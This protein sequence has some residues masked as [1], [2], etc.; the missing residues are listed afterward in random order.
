VYV[1]RLAGTSVFDPI[2][3]QVGKVRDVVLLMGYPHRQR[4]RAVGLVLEVPG[5]RRVFIPLSRV[6]SMDTGQVITTGLVNMRR[7]AQRATE[8]LALAEVL[9][10]TVTFV[11]GSGHGTVEDLAIEQMRSQ[12][13]EVTKVYVRRSTG[14]RGLSD[15]LRRRRGEL[16]LVDTGQIK[17]LGIADL[18]Q[19]ATMLVAG[20]EEM[21]AA[22]IADMLHDMP[23]ERQLAVA[24]ELDD[25][26][27]ADV[28]EEL[29]DDDQ[30]AILSHLG[31][32]RA[33]DVL[34]EMEPD[35]AADLLSELSAEEQEVFLEAM[36]PEEADDLRRLM[37]YEDNTAGGLMTSE[38]I[39]VPPEATVAEALAMV[40]KTEVSPFLAAAVFVCRPPM[41]T[42]TGRYLGLVH[43]QRLL[44]EPPH[45]AIGNYV[46]S[47]IASLGA[48][49]GLQTIT[50]RL[51]TYNLVSLPVTDPAGRL[52]GAVTADDVLDHLLPEDWREL[53]DHEHELREGARQGAG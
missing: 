2:G 33:A 8:G 51:A 3:D 13:W 45:Q 17:D 14:H 10:R 29:P 50:R 1:A 31:R 38:P 49:A 24:G 5:R 20:L 7:F 11:D 16:V 26:R 28:L 12:D 19:P 30:V 25:A 44:R 27:L 53:D 23:R 42:P 39:V 22:D 6:T 34:E 46:D 52:I 9:D 41:E 18:G 43:I 37:T 48:A 15:R 47:D 36:E 35:D 32:D 4:P 21:K 40:R